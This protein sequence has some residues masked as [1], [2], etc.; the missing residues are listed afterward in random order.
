LI[1]GPGGIAWIDS[2]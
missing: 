1:V 2:S